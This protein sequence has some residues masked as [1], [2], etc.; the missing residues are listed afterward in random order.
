V[1]NRRDDFAKRAPANFSLLSGP[2]RL[3]NRGFT[4]LHS[5]LAARD[6]LGSRN[7]A[8]AQPDFACLVLR[9][10]LAGRSVA[11]SV[12]MER[13]LDHTVFLLLVLGRAALW[14]AMARRAVVARPHHRTGPGRLSYAGRAKKGDGRK[15]LTASAKSFGSAAS[16]FFQSP[17]RGC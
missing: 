12:C 5:E 6:A 16:N 11:K 13:S 4:S 15:D 1:G 17:V 14:F 2:D 3:R 7:R 10:D 9:L 8:R